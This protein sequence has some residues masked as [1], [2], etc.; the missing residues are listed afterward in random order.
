MTFL[1]AHPPYSRQ[2]KCPEFSDE[3]KLKLLT[4]LLRNFY[5][6]NVLTT[7]NCYV[8]SFFLHTEHK[9]SMLPRCLIKYFKKINSPPFPK[10]NASKNT[11]KKIFFCNDDYNGNK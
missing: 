11:L 7:A 3:S 10:N 1:Q 6:R 9:F 8:F 4:S 5:I 2:G